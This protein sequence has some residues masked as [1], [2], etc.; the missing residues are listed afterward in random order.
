MYV[1]ME[2]ITNFHLLPLHSQSKSIIVFLVL[3]VQ[4]LIS[5]ALVNLFTMY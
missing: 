4:Y 5:F 3:M 2:Y 1:Y